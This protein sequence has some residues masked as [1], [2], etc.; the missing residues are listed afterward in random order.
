MPKQLFGSVGRI[1]AVTSCKGGVGKSTVSFGIASQLASRGH[2]VGIYDADVNGPSLPTQVSICDTGIQPAEDGWSMPPLVHHSGIKLMSFGWFRNES[3]APIWGPAAEVDPRGAGKP[4]DLAIQLLHTTTWGE[5]DFL[6]VDTPPG[7]GEIPMAISARGHLAGAVV[8]TTPSKLAAA[9]V[10][11]GV[12]MLNRFEV[13]VVAVVENMSSFKCGKCGEEHFPF[14]HGHLDSVLSLVE[15][16]GTKVPSFRLPI[17]ATDDASDSES[18][19]ASESEQ[20]NSLA[21]SLEN[22]SVGIKHVQLPQLAWHE[23]PNWPSKL[24]FCSR[25]SSHGTETRHRTDREFLI[26]PPTHG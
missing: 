24:Y 15:S 14:G 22:G 19:L 1:I 17:I 4:G 11:R 16:G 6:I 18:L 3:G 2:R 9:D 21:E 20:L 23:R 8:V 25:K 13:P 10:V 5:L 26:S 12:S 7:T